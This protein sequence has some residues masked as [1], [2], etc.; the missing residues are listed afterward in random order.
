LV[1]LQL[2]ALKSRIQ[3]IILHTGQVTLI[4]AGFTY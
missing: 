4:D 1:M 2:W 3:I